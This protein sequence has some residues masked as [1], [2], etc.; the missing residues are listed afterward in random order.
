MKKILLIIALML[1]SFPAMADNV[2]IL[3][4]EGDVVRQLPGNAQI[5]TN[6]GRRDT[7]VIQ[8]DDDVWRRMLLGPRERIYMPNYGRDT[9]GVNS[10]C[11]PTLSVSDRNKCVGDYIKAQ[12]KIRKKY[13]N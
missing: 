10:V 9:G 13:N 8:G 6:P 4:S 3:Q 12:D 1:V 7:V 2:T 5:V 11:P